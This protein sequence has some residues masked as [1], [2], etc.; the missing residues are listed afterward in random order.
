MG[1]GGG[2]V[3]CGGGDV[4]CAGGDVGCG[5]NGGDAETDVGSGA[6]TEVACAGSG[7]GCSGTIVING[8]A[9]PVASTLARVDV[10]RSA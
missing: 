6:G 10:A 9:V 8:L 3:G 4:G 1:C 5:G 2:D 7:V